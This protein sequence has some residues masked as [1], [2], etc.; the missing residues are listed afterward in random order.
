MEIAIAK[1]SSLE[2]TITQLQQLA[3]FAQ[4]VGSNKK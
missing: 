4:S 3:S 1:I 2:G